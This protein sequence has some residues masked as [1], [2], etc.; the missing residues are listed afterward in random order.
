MDRGWLVE[1]IEV[2]TVDTEVG[3]VTNV[4]VGSVACVQMLEW[5]IQRLAGQIQ[6]L[7]RWIQK[8]VYVGEV[9]CLKV[10]IEVVGWLQGLARC[11]YKGW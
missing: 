10:N 5:R 1:D 8:S 6:S 2:G 4:Y 11:M 9:S 7:V 3:I